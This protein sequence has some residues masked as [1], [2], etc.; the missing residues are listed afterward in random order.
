MLL[1]PLQRRKRVSEIV[2]LCFIVTLALFFIGNPI[3][4]KVKKVLTLE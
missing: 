4:Q 1:G 2:M 3:D